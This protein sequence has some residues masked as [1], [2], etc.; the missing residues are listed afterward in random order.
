MNFVKTRFLQIL[1]AI[2][3]FSLACGILEIFSRFY[4]KS[5]FIDTNVYLQRVEPQLHRASSLPGLTYELIPGATAEN[6]F[7]GIN[8]QGIRDGEY[9]VPKP[10][11]VY[12]IIVLGDSVTFGMEY[13]LEQTYPKI[14]ERLLNEDKIQEVRFEVLN[15]GVCA[16]NA[17]QKY[18]FLEKK[19]L[20]Y[21]PD[22][23][24][25]QF[26]ND[27]Y[28]RNAVFIPSVSEN[29][30][31]L[32]KSITLGEYFAA[33]FPRIMPVEEGFDR[34]LLRHSALYRLI[35]KSLYD[36]L[37]LRD[38]RKY[39]PA[40]YRFAGTEDLNESMRINKE[41]FKSFS[42][43]AQEND[44]NVV[45]LLVPE[46][47]NQEKMDPWIREECPGLYGFKVIDLFALLKKEG[48]DLRLFRINPRSVCHLNKSGHEVA[49][50]L[51][52][53]WLKENQ[54]AR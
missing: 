39:I 1:C 31:G 46:L 43:L 24:I 5:Y 41:V 2:F 40:A 20:V 34:T 12:R 7:F 4:E 44:F 22:L 25:F 45:L 23:V 36:Y 8:S 35:N 38:P 30:R 21:Q 37:S 47:D 29:C 27:D 51:I 50:R 3:A 48:I 13:P 26:I 52:C 42:C 53:R 15:A 19:L 28:Y 18:V 32:H 33:N 54:L 14:L 11:G 6:K 16:Y 49:A 10:E 9:A 17:L